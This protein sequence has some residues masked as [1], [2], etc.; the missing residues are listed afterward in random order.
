MKPAAMITFLFVVI[1]SYASD[2]KNKTD[3]KRSVEETFVTESSVPTLNNIFGD[4]CGKGL[5]NRRQKRP[6]G[7][8]AM[9]LGPGSIAG[10]SLDGFL[11]PKFA[12]EAG[13][14]FRNL[15]GDVSY[16]LG[17]RYHI[18]GGTPLNLTPYI[19]AYTAFHYTGRDVRNHAVYFPV[20]L[21][22]IKKNGVTWAAEVAY[23][24]SIDTD[25]KWHGAFKIGYRF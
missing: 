8:N 4:K 16:F 20:G 17:G 6:I 25:R 9:A 13:A 18:L 19:G 14:G 7:V 11:G 23:Q 21:H 1:F 12:L 15:Q 2:D 10:V 24:S 5:K 22:R 3:K